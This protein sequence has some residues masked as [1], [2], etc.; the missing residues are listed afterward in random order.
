ML[1]YHAACWK[2]S[3]MDRV[4]SG[5]GLK[6][7][8]ENPCT[9]EGSVHFSDILALVSQNAGG[10]PLGKTLSGSILTAQ[11]LLPAVL[12]KRAEFFWVIWTCI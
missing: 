4:R 2:G 8:V 11:N 6:V 1:P 10:T 3:P 5:R 9:L 12:E 7:V